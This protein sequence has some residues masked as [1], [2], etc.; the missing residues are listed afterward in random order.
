ML[1]R[2]ITAITLAAATLTLVVATTASA[3]PGQAQVEPGFAQVVRTVRPL[4]PAAACPTDLFFSEYIEG[5]SSNKALEIYNG[6]GSAI[7]FASNYTVALY[8]NGSATATSVAT[9]SGTVSNGDVYVI[10]NPSASIVTITAQSDLASGT[11]NF[12]G[13]DAVALFHN[14][15]MID[16]IGQ[17]G[18]DPGSEWGTGLTSTAD[19]TL[20]RLSSIMSGD[21][22][23]SDVFTP[24]VEWAGYA[25]DTTSYLGWHT[26]DV[27]ALPSDLALA[28]SG[29]TTAATSETITY[30]LNFSN[31]GGA[32]ATATQVTDTLPT[33]VSFVTYTAS[34]PVTF[35]QPSADTLVWEVGDVPTDAVNSTIQVVATIAN[36]VAG[37][38]VF[39]NS[40]T[41]ATTANETAMA[42]NTATAATTI[43][44]P[45]L[46]LTKAVE[47][48]ANVAYHGEVT[49]TI[50]LQNSG[51]LDA[52]NVLVTD[53][54]PAE[55]DFAQ[56]IDQPS[57]AGVT[58]DDVTWN[59]TVS[60]SQTITFTF[61]VTHVGN[62]NDIVTNTAEYAHSSGSG[63][64]DATFMVMSS[65]PDLSIAKSA[66]PNIN[67]TYQGEVTYTVTLNNGGAA[68]A[69]GVLLTD[70]LPLSTTFARW[71]NQPAGAVEASGEITWSGVVSAG[72]AIDFIFAVTQAGDYGQTITNT[73]QYD[74]ASGLG[75]AEAAFTVE[76]LSLVTFIYHDAE[77]VVQLSEDVYLAG[78]FNGWNSNAISLTADSGYTT[79]TATLDLPAGSYQYKYI[80]KSG[81]DQWD[82]LNTD[83]RNLTVSSA[84]TLNDYRNVVAGW[85]NLNGPAAQTI[86]LGNPTAVIS[87]Q[88]YV[89]NV[90]NPAGAGRGL[91]AEVGYG[92]NVN[93]GNWSWLAAPYLTN[94]GNNDTYGAA[95]TPTAGGV[96]SYAT[97][98]NGNWGVGNPN[99]TWAY[100]DLNGA[101]FSLD[102]A[103][104]LTVTLPN[105]PVIINELDSDT[106]GDDAA[107]YIELYNG[108]TGSAALDGMTLVFFNGSNDLSYYA[109]DLDG[110]QIAPNGYFVVGNPLVPG[111]VITFAPGSFG[112]LQNG[113]DAVALYWGSAVD[114]PNNTPLT[115]TNLSNVIDAVVYD[116]NDND[117]TGLLALLNPGQPQVNESGGGNSATQ[118]IGRCP[119]GS[120]GARNTDTY[121][122]LTPTPNTGNA[123][124][125]SYDAAILK[126]GPSSIQPGA[127]VTYTIVYSN[128]GLS[129]LTGVVITD[130]LPAGLTYITDTSGLPLISTTPLVWQVGSLTR[131]LKSFQLVAAASS[132]VSGY[133]TNTA[134][135]ASA[136]ADGTP[137]NNTSSHSAPAA[138]F[139]LEV[140]KSADQTEVFIETGVSH[141]LTYT[142]QIN[143]RSLISATTRVTVTDVLPTSF[144]YAFDDSGVAHT[145]TG[146]VGDPLVWV[147]TNPINPNGSLMFHVAVTVSDAVPG[148][149]LYRNQVSI[150]SE[151]SDP[152][153]F[154]N[155]AQDA[156]VM[157]WKLISLTEARTLP[158][159][160]T[161][162]VGG[163][164]NFPPGLVSQPTQANDEFLMQDAPLGTTGLSVFYNRSTA[165][166]SK[167]AV[168][169]YVLARG[170]LSEFNGKLEVIVFTTTHAVSTGLNT[171]LTPWVRTTGQIA[172][173]TEGVFV[174]TE[175]IV[176]STSS[177]HLFINDGSGQA[178]IFRDTDTP[179]L[180]FAG[181]QVGDKV[182][183]TGVG[184]QFD[185]SAPYDSG[186]EVIVRYQSDVMAYPTVTSV[187]PAANATDVA[188]TA[189]VS[190]TFNMTMTNVG[191]TTFTLRGPSGAVAGTVTYNTATRTATIDPTSDLANSTR[192]TATLSADLA[193]SNGLTLTQDY[194]WSFTT[195]AALPD[196]ST[197]TKVNS[198]NG[199]VFSGNWVTYTIQLNN[200]GN[201]NATAHVTDVLSSYYTVANLLDFS[202][203]TTGTLT[204][205]GVVTAGQSVTLHFV[206][207]VKGVQ[208]LPRGSAL[209]F[210]TAEV[211]DGYQA[212]FTIEDPA[213]PTITI[214]GL[215]LPLIQR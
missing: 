85:A 41:A 71:V 10:I 40:V 181:Y 121:T 175:G 16:V 172:E 33:E 83:N 28:K 18:F 7:T 143:N 103:G 39:T 161:V 34:I 190:A 11:V 167:F 113:A 13:D 35:T 188:V 58:A 48:S 109:Q 73:A 106:P 144:A 32:T 194:V 205:T 15:V 108:G 17:I 150:A 148:S 76:P 160:S 62:Y 81:G 52:N 75:S 74:H 159:S 209:L 124:P 180:S 210:N 22:I 19:N 61:V 2:L 72:Q 119:N 97:R 9:L 117:D 120:G 111:V 65:S 44:A 193:A 24:S 79:F 23:G 152:I 199:A 4:A 207:Q 3:A 54:L 105:I 137:D 64:A 176:A 138:S 132:S 77:D 84:A 90:T 89:Q 94:N 86:D 26:T 82:W 182:R 184:T 88:V 200:T 165:K 49:Y 59:G 156:G 47:P 25:I 31:T 45:A 67:V 99:S 139:D 8:S 112:F 5:S 158:L 63:L 98:Y 69:A 164:V 107:E 51:D 128:A 136:E 102:Q 157:V 42:N 87:G 78:A 166:F 195:V 177:L 68:D 215:Y 163:Y 20:V 60:A 127:N 162:Y 214:Y 38:T 191:D 116:T 212:T 46:S 204:W 93:P 110:Y 14:G 27:C 208:N 151:P 173:T 171:P 145:G 186:Y 178:D 96:F 50:A 202:Q 21:P 135:I 201:L 168:G 91:K 92:S 196:L 155:T 174:Q 130:E 183:V 43:N 1:R 179:N 122:T 197:S 149:A 55:V 142:I 147:V 133:L 203:P 170:T 53:T 30:T 56:W 129:T 213:P 192:Y 140:I 211:N 206:A 141:L 154:N 66:T 29:P 100:G 118:S 146:T 125:A 80:V 12:N 57:G 104:V 185:T 114:F 123:C 37:G 153:V 6:T 70:T 198:V 134:S 115:S 169:D 36:N 101:P 95:L 126:S 189:N 187:A 131:T